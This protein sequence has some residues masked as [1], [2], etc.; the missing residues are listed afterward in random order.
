LLERHLDRAECGYA[1]ALLRARRYVAGAG[2]RFV[3]F[4]QPQV[5]TLK[6]RSAYESW[7]VENELKMLHG[8][9]RAY[10]AGYPRL[11][12]ALARVQAEGVESFDLSDVLDD[13]ALGQEY[14]LDFCHVNHAANERLARRI[15]ELAFAA[16]R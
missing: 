5:F 15:Y 14:Y 16:S 12:Q 9:D 10:S 4:L 11:R 3:H 7:V 1:E 6:Q 8:L 2:G 13:R